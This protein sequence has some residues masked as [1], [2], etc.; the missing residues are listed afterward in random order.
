MMP[1]AIRRVF[2][3]RRARIAASLA[4]CATGAAFVTTALSASLAKVIASHMPGINPAVLSTFVVAMWV[5]GVVAY[6]LSRARGEH[7]FA[8]EMSRVRPARRRSRSRISSA[9]RTRIPTTSRAAWPIASRFGR[10]RCR[11]WPLASSC[12]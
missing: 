6:T 1:H 4:I 12:R 9:S 8:V 7:Q 2:V 5:V 3:A 10:L 11:C